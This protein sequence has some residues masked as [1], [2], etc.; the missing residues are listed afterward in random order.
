MQFLAPTNIFEGVV[1][2]NQAP[3]ASNHA[4]TK[5]YLEANAVVGIAAD[6]AQYVEFVTVNGQKQLKVKPLTITDV[7]VDT[8]AQDLGAWVQANYTGVEKQEGDIIVLT[9]VQG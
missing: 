1:Q 7:A 5:A 2:L 4:V 8:V 3:S 9:A 6:S